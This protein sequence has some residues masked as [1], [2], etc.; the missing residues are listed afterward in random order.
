[1][2]AGIAVVWEIAVA[3][4]PR[5]PFLL[6]FWG[7]PFIA[8]GTYLLIGRFLWDIQRRRHTVYGV[9]DRRIVIMSGVRSSKVT[10]FALRSIP[11]ITLA[12]EEDGSGDVV[13]AASDARHVAIGGLVPKGRVVP[14][15]LE[16]LPDA[17][18]VYDIIRRAQQR[19]NR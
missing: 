9:T 16:F 1:M 17:H 8:M 3:F 12:A 19:A 4:D 5:A 2:W 7:L 14:P 11:A 13:L 18:M 6:R 10:T 15:M